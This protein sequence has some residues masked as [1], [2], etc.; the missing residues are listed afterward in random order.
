MNDLQAVAL[1]QA[2]ADLVVRGGTVF[3]SER[4]DFADRD[5]AVVDGRVAALFEDASHVVGDETTVVDATDC[6]V[7]PG[8]VD[9]HTHVDYHHVFEAVYHHV[10]AGGTT[11]VVSEAAGIGALFDERGVEELLAATA[12]L[13]IDLRV[14]V[15]TAGFVDTFEPQRLDADGEDA[16]LACLDDD[17]VVGVGE[18]PWIHLV[19]HDSPVERLYDRARTV[20]KPISGHGAGC[21]GEKLTAFASIVDNDH[22]SIAGEEV[23][24]R[25]ENGIHAIGRSGS[26]RDDVQ[27]LADG[28]RELG[29]DELSSP[30]TGCGLPTSSTWATWTRCSAGPSTLASTPRTPC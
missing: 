5:V 26:I 12:D 30:P 27:A 19:G 9:A 18:T 2:D 8:F 25:V 21:R 3:R 11:A 22:E 16:M 7:T 1:G 6:V 24:E 4:R 13:P 28:Y 29:A 20:G 14:T 10:L 15:P 23:V 17:R